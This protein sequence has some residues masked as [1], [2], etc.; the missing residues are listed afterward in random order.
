MFTEAP[1]EV[2]RAGASDTDAWV[3]EELASPRHAEA[4]G[5]LDEHGNRLVGG[6][7]QLVQN[8]VERLYGDGA[9]RVWFVGIEE[10][11]DGRVTEALAV[12]LPTEKQVREALLA[13]E[14]HFWGLAAS[15]PDV[16]QRYL[17]F[18]FD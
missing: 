12:E 9:P 7:P 2:I 13:R 15:A 8:L 10:A 17:A 4:L 5:W 6:D 1:I 18:I 3:A 11:E 16:G 14:A